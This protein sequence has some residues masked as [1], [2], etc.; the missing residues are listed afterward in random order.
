MHF[1]S[2]PNDEILDSSKFK[3]FADKKILTKKLKFMLGREKNIVGKEI[4]LV[5]SIF[6]FSHNVFK[7]FLFQRC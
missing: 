2:L 4:L 7:S 6:Y 1:K 5:T 3:A